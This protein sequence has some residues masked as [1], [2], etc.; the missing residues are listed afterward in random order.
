MEEKNYLNRF[1]EEFIKNSAFRLEESL[2]MIRIALGKISE[3][4]VWETPNESLSSIG[5]LILHCCG[6]LTQYGITSL[7]H[8]EDKRDRDSE[9][10][11]S[12]SHTK[13]ELL[14]HLS[15]TITGV[16]EAMK[17][18]TDHRYIEESE[19]QGFRFSG[20]GNIIHTVEHLSYHTG[21]IA[22]RV[23]L[24][25]NQPLGF[26]EGIDLNQKNK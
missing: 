2:R 6:N 11:T 23:K 17:S 10:Q 14:E 18:I 24:L 21:Q 25:N 19:V 26:Y 22:F 20:M 4:Q 16:K 13:T 7:L 3:E 15:A 5:N 8:L 1:K 9:F 12:R